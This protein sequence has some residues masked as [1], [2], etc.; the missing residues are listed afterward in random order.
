MISEEKKNKVM[1]YARSLLGDKEL[2]FVYFGGS[3]AYGLY[4]EGKSDMDVNIVT[5]EIHGY[6]HGTIENVDFFVYGDDHCMK[7]QN[8]DKDMPL[9]YK[10]YIDEVLA[11]DETLIYLNPRYQERYE[12]YKNI[13][14]EKKIV[15]FL[16]AF[17]DYHQDII[18]HYGNLP[19]KRLYHLIRMREIIENYLK[20][21]IYSIHLSE[22]T[23][24][25]SKTFKNNFKNE[26]GVSMMQDYV[27][28]ALEYLKGVYATL[29]KRKQDE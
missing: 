25:R 26:V 17:I 18:H 19:R 21:G 15:P 10:I 13:Q 12:E 24:I 14:M 4:E 28:P 29:E 8:L 6:L 1:K 27:L 7:K 20:T 16:K 11:L 22:E 23:K 2:M 3:I 5:P 9:Y